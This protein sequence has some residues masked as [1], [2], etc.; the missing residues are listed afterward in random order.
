M[1]DQL[2]FEDYLDSEREATQE[3]KMDFA[4][5]SPAPA[6]FKFNDEKSKRTF[7]SNSKLLEKVYKF[8]FGPN[9]FQEFSCGYVL[10]NI[11][12]LPCFACS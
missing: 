9:S 11:L 1:Q 7:F 2:Q 10:L 8:D 4:V 12:N 3:D 5:S 6:F